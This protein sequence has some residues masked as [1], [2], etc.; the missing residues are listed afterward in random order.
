[1]TIDGLDER[2]AYLESIGLGPFMPATLALSTIFLGAW[3]IYLRDPR[4]AGNRSFR[5][6]LRFCLSP[7]MLLHPL[8]GKSS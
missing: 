4:H 8:A 5:G 2:D 3:L 1:L 6:Y 7:E